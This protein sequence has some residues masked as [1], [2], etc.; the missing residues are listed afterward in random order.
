MPSS[1]TSFS[2]TKLRP[3]LVMMTFASTIFMM[4]S[5]LPRHDAYTL[6][7]AAGVPAW[8]GGRPRPTDTRLKSP[9]MVCL[10]ALAA[11][12]KLQRLFRRAAGHQAVD[13]AGREAVAAADAID[14]AH[15]VVLAVMERAGR[16]V[17]EHRAPAVVARRKALAQRDRHLRRGELLRDALGHVLDRRRD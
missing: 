7:A 4:N 12:A 17:V 11:T 6:H 8:P 15:V 5:C 9:G 13:Q 14:Q 10:S 2:V 1:V 3:G 16:L